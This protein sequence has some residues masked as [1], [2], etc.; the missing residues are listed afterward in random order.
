MTGET[1][2]F[3]GVSAAAF[4][5]SGTITA[6]SD[7]I[8]LWAAASSVGSTGL[9]SASLT[10]TEEPD[11]LTAAGTVTVA[12]HTSDTREPPGL[13]EFL[14]GSF[15]RA[16]DIEA[17]KDH[18]EELFERDCAS[19]MSERRAVRRY[20]AKVLRS[21]WPQI[22]QWINRVGWAALIAAVLKR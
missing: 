13:A 20:W 14:L 21:L 6:G 22:W 7:T 15:A 5:D 18:F 9:I 12:G 11:T 17:L 1:T 3:T 10:I 4:A 8:T 2:T 19:G 16:K